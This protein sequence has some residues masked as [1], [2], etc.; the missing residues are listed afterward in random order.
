MHNIYFDKMMNA[1]KLGGFPM[2]SIAVTKAKS[3]HEKYG[4]ISVVFNKSTIDPAVSKVFNPSFD[5]HC[6]K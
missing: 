2:P 1:L 3:G 4:P 5:K 6:N